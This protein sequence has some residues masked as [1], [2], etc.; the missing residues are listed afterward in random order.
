MDDFFK[1]SIW[2]NIENT[3]EK[4]NLDK[5]LVKRVMVEFFL[6]ILPR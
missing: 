3:R 6:E 1:L 4:R 5:K 2:R